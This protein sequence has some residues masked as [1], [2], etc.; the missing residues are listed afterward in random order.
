MPFG[1]AVVGGGWL[2]SLVFVGCALRSH[3]VPKSKRGLWVALLI[4]AN[5]FVLPFFWFWY[6]WGTEQSAQADGRL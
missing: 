4:F 6:I 5:A 2:V 3:T 1:M